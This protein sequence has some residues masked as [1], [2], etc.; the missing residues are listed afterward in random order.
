MAR[1]AVPA[2]V[3]AALSLQLRAAKSSLA[4]MW[5]NGA[6]SRHSASSFPE[7]HKKTVFVSVSRHRERTLEKMAWPC[8]SAMTG[9]ASAVKPRSIPASAKKRA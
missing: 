5:G 1:R 7:E 8:S 2:A 9:R 6:P 3:A 4:R